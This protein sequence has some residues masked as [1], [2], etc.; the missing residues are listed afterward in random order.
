MSR[1]NHLSG[2]MKALKEMSLIEDNL[3]TVDNAAEKI[4]RENSKSNSAGQKIK[5]DVNGN[6]IF[7]IEPD[8]IINWEFHDRPYNEMG[9]IDSLA[10]EFLD[11]GQ[12]QP[13]VVRYARGEN[14]LAGYIYELI[15]GERR[16]RAAGKAGIKLKCIVRDINDVDAAL[17]QSAENNNRQNLSD[18]AKGMSYAKLIDNK[19]LKQS[20]IVKKI[21]IPKINLIRLL[22]FK[23]I[24]VE[25]TKEISDFTKI[26]ARTAYELYILSQ[27]SPEHIDA[28]ILL[29]HKIRE[30]KIGCATIVREVNKIIKGDKSLSNCEKIFS[31][32]GR[33]LFTWSDNSIRFPKSINLSACHND[34][35]KSIK[36]AIEKHLQ[37]L[38]QEENI[39]EQNL[40]KEDL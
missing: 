16:W 23:K 26:T 32:D 35:K 21:G 5:S 36:S 17:C 8:K 33:H 2:T 25:I 24:P 11:I 19:V 37:K 18:Y 39:N 3:Q 30:G 27:K 7:L 29:A 4:K 1:P 28:I 40:K 38:I 15:I 34:I 12:Q 14:K 31:N 9:D 13:C 22:S 10:E 20:E 6:N